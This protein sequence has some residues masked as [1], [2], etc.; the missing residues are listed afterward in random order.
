MEFNTIKDVNGEE[1]RYPKDLNFTALFNTKDDEYFLYATYTNEIYTNPEL[2]EIS[3]EE[4]NKLKPELEAVEAPIIYFE[5]K[6]E[7]QVFVDTTYITA[8]TDNMTVE[9]YLKLT[10]EKPLFDI[11]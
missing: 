6:S 2:I 7:V 3:T 11:E 5:T 4:Y 1:H 10:G 8:M 9:E